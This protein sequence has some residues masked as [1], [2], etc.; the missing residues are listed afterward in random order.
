MTSTNC[1][2]SRVGIPIV[3]GWGYQNGLHVGGP[4]NGQLR[5]VGDVPAALHPKKIIVFLF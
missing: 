3:V 1:L 4:Q 2:L 5:G